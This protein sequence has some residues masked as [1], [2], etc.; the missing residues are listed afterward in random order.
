MADTP[1]W[2]KEAEEK[3]KDEREDMNAEV[4]S[5]F[6]FHLF[7]Y[8][9]IGV[10]FGIIYV[11]NWMIVGGNFLPNREAAWLIAAF[12]GGVPFTYLMERHDRIREV[13]EQ[14][15]IRLEMKIDA[16]LDRHKQ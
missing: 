4:K 14:R 15:L 10:V 6:Y 11:V 7:L 9:L 12:I 5:G 16:L 3:Y 2:K 13:R 8:L 1:D